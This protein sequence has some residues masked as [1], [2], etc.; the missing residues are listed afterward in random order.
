ML[1]AVLSIS[2]LSRSRGQ[3]CQIHSHLLEH[4]Y[5]RHD[6]DLVPCQ[7]AEPCHTTQACVVPMTDCRAASAWG[8]TDVWKKQ[9][10]AC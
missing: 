1:H 3:Q 8:L 7:V 6:T 2:P 9:A 4:P 10:D 5:H